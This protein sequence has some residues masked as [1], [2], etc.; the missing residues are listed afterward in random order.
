MAAGS[1]AGA[2]ASSF[3]LLM[4]LVSR[5]DIAKC[6]VELGEEVVCSGEMIEYWMRV[7]LEGRMIRRTGI[8]C[9]HYISYISRQRQRPSRYV[10]LRRRSPTHMRVMRITTPRARIANSP[11]L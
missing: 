8:R 9:E 4:C 2:A 3:G 11:T 6:Q 10:N 7:V 5:A 1:I